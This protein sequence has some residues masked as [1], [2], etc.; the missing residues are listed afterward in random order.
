MEKSIWEFRTVEL[1]HVF[2]HLFQNIGSLVNLGSKLTQN[3][4]KCD[5]SLYLLNL[6]NLDISN[7]WYKLLKEVGV[8]LEDIFENLDRFGG[9]I[10]NVQPKE[11]PQLSCHIL[12]LTGQ[13]NN[14]SSKGLDRPFGNFSV[15]ICDILKQFVYDFGDV[16][17]WSNL[18]QNFK[19]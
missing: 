15:N 13:P 16:W 6:V 17:F 19:F 1:F 9:H 7:N 12:W 5:F 14:D 2:R 8:L 11:I 3:P 18:G 10:G 4:S